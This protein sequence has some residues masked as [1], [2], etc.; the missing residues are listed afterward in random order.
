MVDVTYFVE[1]KIRILNYKNTRRLL[2]KQNEYS[3]FNTK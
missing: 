2:N 1:L 3:N